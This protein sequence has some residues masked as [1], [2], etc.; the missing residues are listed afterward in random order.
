MGEL[1]V[2]VFITGV[3]GRGGGGGYAREWRYLTIYSL[4][5]CVK[6]LFLLVINP[7]DYQFYSI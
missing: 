4:I 1:I 3:R 5:A 2:T 6:N 7:N